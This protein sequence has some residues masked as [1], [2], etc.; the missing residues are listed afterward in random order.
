LA[1][2][3]QFYIAI[4]PIGKSV[5]TAEDFF[6]AYLALPVVMLFWAGGFAWKRTGW[7][8]THQIDVDSGRRELDW[9]EIH[10]YRAKFATWPLWKRFLSHLF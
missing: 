9:E 2:D 10:A 5:G 1:N 3:S 6:M 8:R 7:L 4:S